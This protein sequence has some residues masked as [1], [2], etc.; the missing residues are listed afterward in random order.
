MLTAYPTNYPFSR[1]ELKVMA[2]AKW[3]DSEGW[4]REDIGLDPAAELAVLNGGNFVSEYHTAGLIFAKDDGP[5]AAN[6]GDTIDR[7]A[8]QLGMGVVEYFEFLNDPDTNADTWPKFL[9]E[10]KPQFVMPSAPKI[11]WEPDKQ[12]DYY[13]NTMLPQFL[14]Y[15]NKY[16]K[17]YVDYGFDFKLFGAG[18]HEKVF[19][20]TVAVKKS[21]NSFFGRGIIETVSVAT[22]SKA[23]FQEYFTQSICMYNMLTALRELY[24][25]QGKLKPGTYTVGRLTS[26]EIA[27][28]ES[29]GM[30]NKNVTTLW[31]DGK[32]VK[33]QHRDD[34]SAVKHND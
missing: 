17:H 21:Y 10:H 23:R 14:N 2:N 3:F 28:L 18:G 9:K 29:F 24:T 15:F 4:G 19:K 27:V 30:E 1:H 26:Q 6:Y 7:V 13:F 20:L 31:A 33:N 16:T 5:D 34:R 11:S 12:E 8:E 22:S 32:A 25:G